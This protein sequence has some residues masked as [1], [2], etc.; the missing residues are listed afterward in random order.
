MAPIEVLGP[1]ALSLIIGLP[2]GRSIGIPGD[3][4][5]IRTISLVIGRA[6]YDGSRETAQKPRRSIKEP[7]EKIGCETVQADLPS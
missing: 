7:P 4:S 6:I 3:A 2:V 5:E 1:I